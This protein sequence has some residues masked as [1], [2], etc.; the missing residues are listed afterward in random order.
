MG[1]LRNKIGFC[2]IEGD[3]ASDI[4]AQLIDG[5]G[6]SVVQINTG[7][8]CHLDANMI[9]SVIDRQKSFKNSILFIENV[10]NL[11]CPSSFDL[12]EN[13]KMVVASVPEGH[14]KPYKY[15]SMFETADIIVL[16]KIDLIPYVGFDRP[17]FYK[18]LSA[19]NGKAPVFEISCRTGEGLDSLAGWMQDKM[20]DLIISR[21][22]LVRT[23][24]MR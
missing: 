6:I 21:S 11:V 19:V 12:G 20:A 14:D 5:M 23:E 4:D 24:G 22:V 13:C 17:Y 18:G 16:N 3:I 2:V 15:I 7:G 10:G 9:N 1:L 8:G